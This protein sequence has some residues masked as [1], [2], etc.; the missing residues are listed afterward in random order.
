MNRFLLLIRHSHSQ[1]IAD[2]PAHLWSLSKKGREKCRHFAQ[3]L[4]PYQPTRILTSHEPKTLQ[5]GQLLAKELALPCHTAPNLH[6]HERATTPWF[7]SEEAFQAAVRQLFIHPDQLMLGEETANQAL[8]RF[9]AAIHAQLEQYP[10]DCLAIVTHGTV[11]T[12]FVGQHN[13]IELVP[14]W[15]NLEMPALIPLTLPHFQ[16]TPNLPF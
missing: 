10:H 14:F 8:A 6:E 13:P 5:T 2:V 7:D 1:P 12:L 15:Q 4:L 3:Q 11:L 9:S 16:L